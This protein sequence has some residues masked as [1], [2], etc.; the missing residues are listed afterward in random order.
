MTLPTDQRPTPPPRSAMQPAAA[1]PPALRIALTTATTAAAALHT[2][3]ATHDALASPSSAIS[4]SSPSLALSASDRRLFCT[5]HVDELKRMADDKRN[6]SEDKKEELRQLVG[7]GEQ[8]NNTAQ[9][10]RHCES[11]KAGGRLADPSVVLCVC[12]LLLSVFVIA[13]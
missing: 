13:F 2:A 6:A 11:E 8:C 12:V 4:S 9:A 10:T 5:H 7:S 1:E 3:T